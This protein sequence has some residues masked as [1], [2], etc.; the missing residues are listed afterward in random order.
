M[1]IEREGD[2][3]DEEEEE[4][5]EVGDDSTWWARIWSMKVVVAMIDGM[6][7]NPALGLWPPKDRKKD[8]KKERRGY[9]NKDDMY[10]YIWLSEKQVKIWIYKYL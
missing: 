8:R 7:M 1:R 3:D 2:D 9:K 10:A 4:E 6:P 5:E